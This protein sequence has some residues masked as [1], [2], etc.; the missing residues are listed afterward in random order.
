M[1]TTSLPLHRST[2]GRIVLLAVLVLTALVLA[3]CGGDDED[4]GEGG[5]DPAGTV[6]VEARDSLDF[7]A[8]VYQATAGEVTIDYRPDDGGGYHNLLVVGL[9]DELELEV[10]GDESD[11]GTIT[12]D[13]G[14]YVIYCSVAGHREAGMEAELVVS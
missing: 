4:S 13:P 3:A 6:V 5:G 11:T 10:Q 7:D 8:D 14:T 12:L 1:S 9:E 2:V